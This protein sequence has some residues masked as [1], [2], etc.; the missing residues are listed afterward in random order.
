MN[1]II[2]EINEIGTYTKPNAN[3]RKRLRK[4]IKM[5]PITKY[6]RVR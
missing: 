6:D 1:K 2:K 5:L 4:L 3:D